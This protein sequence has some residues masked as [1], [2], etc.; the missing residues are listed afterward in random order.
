[1]KRRKD[2]AKRILT[3]LDELEV[4]ALMEASLYKQ[5]LGADPQDWG[6][7]QA[8]RGLQHHF[9]QVLTKIINEGQASGS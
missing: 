8:M 4:W 6:E 7:V 1:M 2:K 5:W 3:E 9:R